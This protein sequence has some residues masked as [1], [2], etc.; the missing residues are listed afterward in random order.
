MS[1]EQQLQAI[2]NNIQ[3]YVVTSHHSMH[4]AHIHVQ[5]V[6]TAQT[7]QSKIKIIK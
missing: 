7:V 6:V 2:T 4:Y 5:T 3:I 1:R